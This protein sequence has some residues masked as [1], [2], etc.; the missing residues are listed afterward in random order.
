[1]VMPVTCLRPRFFLAFVCLLAGALLYA[2]EEEAP[3]SVKSSE[4]APA[5]SEAQ[6]SE[7]SSDTPTTDPEAE[8]TI[9][10]PRPASETQPLIPAETSKRLVYILPVQDQIVTPTLYILRRGLKLAEENG[11]RTVIIDMD[12]PGG[13]LGPT[14]EIM[15]ALDSFSGEVYTFVDPEAIS[16]GAFISVATDK[17]YFA[18]DGIIGAAEAVSGTGQEIPEGMQRKLKSYIQAKVRSLTEEYRYRSDVM[19][20]MSDPNYE[21]EIDGEVIKKEGELL[22]LTA[23]EAVKEYGD[24]AQPLLGAGIYDSIDDLLDGLY[25]AGNYEIRS[26]EVTWSESLAHYLQTIAPV[27]LGAGML[28]LFVEFKTPGFGIFGVGGI[29][30]LGVVFVSSHL[31]GLAG[32]EAFL[33]FALGIALLMVELFLLPGL[34]FPALIGGVLIL[35]SL[36][37]S[38]ADIWPDEPIDW[39]GGTFAEP[40]LNIAIGMAIAIVGAVLIARFL[41]K[42]WVWNKL[43]LQTAVGDPPAG[44]LVSSNQPEALRAQT[45]AGWPDVG[46]IGTAVTDLFPNGEIEIDGRRYQA[47]S[48]LTQIEHSSRIVVVG[49]QD[50]ALKVELAPREES[51]HG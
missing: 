29:L 31:A 28:L 33:L 40:L 46:T 37:W 24:P 1:M 9:E 15:Q 25:G 7:K 42:T 39:T 30:L 51:S 21:L 35:G 41:P 26:F 14:L 34:V 12:T 22:S 18:P 16:A 48:R 32:Y 19:R 17:I 10:T 3:T 45:P 49:Y 2:A 38:M 43:V 47:K 13:A 23:K 27:L 6:T 8:S 36:V 4:T 20:A 5:D 44:P 50:F 11:I